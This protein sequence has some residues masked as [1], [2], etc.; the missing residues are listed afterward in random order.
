MADPSD[1]VMC[2]NI[3]FMTGLKIVPVIASGSKIINQIKRVYGDKDAD[4]PDDIDEMFEG[5]PL[6]EIDIIINEDEP[7]INV[8]E[9][10]GTS[11]VPPIIRIVNFIFD[12]TFSAHGLIGL[13]TK[14][15]GKPEVNRDYKRNS[16]KD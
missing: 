10:I 14:S 8:Q 6:D 15:K 2:D 13:G 5:E 9:L 11:E 1:I 12:N 4:L 7:D 16:V 3:T